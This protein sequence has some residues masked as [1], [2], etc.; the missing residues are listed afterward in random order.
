[1]AET[2]VG[3]FENTSTAKRVAD[4]L[5]ENGFA[6][7]DVKIVAEGHD[8]AVDTATSTPGTDMLVALERDLR[9]MGASNREVDFYAKGLKRGYSIV[10]AT[11][12]AQQARTAT[13]LMNDNFAIE[14]EEFLGAVPELIPVGAGSVGGPNVTAKLEHHRSRTE[15]ARM[16]SW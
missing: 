3:I 9:S 16:F 2:A 13:E 4:S 11:G 15:G 10:F 12:T 6:G 14:V 7:S 1:M 5:L 8:L